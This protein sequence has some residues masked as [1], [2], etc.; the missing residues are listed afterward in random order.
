MRSVSDHVAL[1]VGLVEPLP[2]CEV[3]LANAWG[4][5]LATDIRAV[6]DSPPFANSAMDGFAVRSEDTAEASAASPVR[7]AVV[8]ESA[9]G[10]PSSTS[11]GRGEAIRIMTGAAVPE[12]ADAVVPQELTN[13][14]AGGVEIL[15]PA[16]PRAHIRAAGE[17]LAAGD[18]VV[19]Q[20][21]RLAA[22]HLAAVAS[23]GHGTV[24]V[25]R[26]PVV[27]VLATG[28]ELVEPGSTL[29]PGH[30]ADSNSPLLAGLL[31]QAGAAALVLPRVG[32]DPHRLLSALKGVSADLIVTAGG[33]SVGAYDV[34][35][36]A[37]A[38]MG[39]DF[40]AV[41]MQPGKP[42]G[43]GMLNG[44]PIAC[45]PGNPVSVYV[46]FAV[47]VAPMIRALTGQTE[48]IPRTAT[49]A[50]PWT[51]PSGKQQFMPVRVLSDGRVQPAAHRGSQSHLV[52]GLA[53]AEGLAV[54]PADTTEVAQGDTVT[55]MEGI[56]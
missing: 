22:T 42:Q 31:R 33:V 34:V 49:V 8:G 28:D 24:S 14:R 35:K 40:A 48:P 18:M 53:R 29:A 51:S 32:D 26:A 12:G 37:L 43:L 23:T 4:L 3:S 27:A 45:L 38:P 55:V 39:V 13:E 50:Q 6:H 5:V 47:V 21:T 2:V 7:L 46:S 25:R 36:E 56:G 20:G 30:I 16:A 1:A 54:I 17:D 15:A 11:L 44:V 19:A 52:A 10:S 41:A 9:A